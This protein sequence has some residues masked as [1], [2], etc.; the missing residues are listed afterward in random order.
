MATRLVIA[1]AGSGKTS[2]LV[3]KALN[4][5][6]S[7]VLITT[8]TESNKEVILRKIVEK[9]KYLP[10]NITVQTWFSFLLQHGVRP[11]QSLLNNALDLK[12]I[13]FYLHQGKSGLREVTRT[14]RPIYWG[15]TEFLRYYFTKDIKIY[16]DKISKFIYKTNVKSTGE[17]ISRISRIYKHIFI[18]EVQDLA[19]WDL[20]LLLLLMSSGSEI[21]M[22]GDPRQAIYETNDSTKYAIY[23]GGNIK[24][25]LTD[26]ASQEMLTIDETTLGRSHRNNAQICDFSSKLFPNMSEITICECVP[27]RSYNNT[28]SGIFLVRESDVN[29]YQEFYKPTILKQK[30]AI[31][32]STTR[33]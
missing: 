2:F 26:H 19:G 28:H 23:R 32:P 8:F 15:E 18:D 13:G 27:C 14:G 22:V 29:K 20:D 30:S 4:I 6:N 16:S 9:N 31:F 21:E 10:K 24:N 12:E 3:E 7:N 17:V 33:A 1:G 5:E 11:Y 25:F